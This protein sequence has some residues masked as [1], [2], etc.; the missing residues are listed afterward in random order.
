MPR[1]SSRSPPL[2][3]RIFSPAVK[4]SP[5]KPAPTARQIVAPQAVAMERPSFGQSVKE[6]FGWGIGTSIARSIFGGGGGG[7]VTTQTVAPAPPP[8]KSSDSGNHEYEQ[9]MKE[10][11]NN[12]EACKQYLQTS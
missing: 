10:S 7:G 6:G 3:T 8:Q 4:P 5:V 9:C 1:S 12:A 2:K 11:S